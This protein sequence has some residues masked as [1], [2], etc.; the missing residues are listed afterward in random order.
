MTRLWRPHGCTCQL[1]VA[2]VEDDGTEVL[3]CIDRGCDCMVCGHEAG[4]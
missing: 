2:E 4:S 3:E 1:D